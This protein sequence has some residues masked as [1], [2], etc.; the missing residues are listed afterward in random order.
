M[1]GHLR[2]ELALKAKDHL[3]IEVQGVGY[4]V[5][6]PPSLQRKLPELGEELK[7]Y[8]YTYVR[9]DRLVLYGF[10]ETKQLELFKELLGV[11][12]IGPKSAISSL[13]TLTVKEFKLAIVK[14]K[15]DVLK[16]IKGI[17][18]KTAQRLILELKGKIDLEQILAE[19]KDTAVEATANLERQ[20]AIDGLLGL[21]YSRREAEAAVKEACGEQSGLTVEE[22]IRQALQSL[23]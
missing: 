22:I 5:N 14:E 20:E 10:L 11:S 7:I 8:T 19:E 17:G 13:A 23:G 4:K 1:I 6:I 21:G 15:V 12:K 18:T 3:I 16:E 9:E 2:G